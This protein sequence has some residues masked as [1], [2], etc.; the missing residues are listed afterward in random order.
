MHK[1]SDHAMSQMCVW[2]VFVC[3]TKHGRALFC[4]TFLQTVGV[5]NE[6]ELLEKAA[7]YCFKFESLFLEKRKSSSVFYVSDQIR[8]NA[9]DLMLRDRC[10][11]SSLHFP[12]IRPCHDDLHLL[13]LIFC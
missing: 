8:C 10:G 11:D 12:E 3:E 9:K 7:A 4:E 6:E 5:C 2:Y 1:W 13:S